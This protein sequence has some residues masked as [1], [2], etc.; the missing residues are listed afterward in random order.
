MAAWNLPYEVQPLG[1]LLLTTSAPI[2]YFQNL[3]VLL[4]LAKLESGLHG[5]L[6]I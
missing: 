3:F 1:W 2:D 5:Y 4:I 6:P